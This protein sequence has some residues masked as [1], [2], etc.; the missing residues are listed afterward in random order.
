MKLL[1]LFCGQGGASMGY[2]RAGF[3]VVGVDNAAQRHY[4]FRF[5]LGDAM[6]YPLD[7][8]DVV[9][10]SPPCQAYSATHSRCKKN[11][12]PHPKLIEPLRARLQ[13]WGG[14]YVIENVERAPLQGAALYCGGAFALGADTAQ[15]RLQL[16][17]HRLFESNRF[18]MTPGCGCGKREKV[19]VY[20]NGGAWANRLS[21]G[22]RGY[23]GN[24][25]ER[26]QAMEID[27]MTIAGL[28]QAIPPA[29]TQHIGEQL[30]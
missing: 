11:P 4:P 21:E 9:H 16:K 28:S 15:G 20:G 10:A 6:M 3:E 26:S 8:F 27:W 30:L 29:Y 24:K 25:A 22:R 23:Q 13:E 5:E 19:G 14:P 2:N 12:C 17:R 1:D 7:G 18:L